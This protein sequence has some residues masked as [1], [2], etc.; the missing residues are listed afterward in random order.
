MLPLL[1]TLRCSAGRI[2]WPNPQQPLHACRPLRK[3]AGLGGGAAAHRRRHAPAALQPATRRRLPQL[4]G[5]WPW[6]RCKVVTNGW[7]P[8]LLKPRVCATT[9]R[10][11]AP[12]V[13]PAGSPHSS[14]RSASCFAHLP[15][16]QAGDS[17][18]AVSYPGCSASLSHNPILGGRLPPAAAAA[19][20]MQLGCPGR[21]YPAHPQVR[22]KSSR[23]LTFLLVHAQAGSDAYLTTRG[24]RSSCGCWQRP[25]PPPSPHQHHQALTLQRRA[26]AQPGGRPCAPARHTRRRGWLGGSHKPQEE[27]AGKPRHHWEWNG[28]G[29][30]RWW[31]SLACR[32]AGLKACVVPMCTARHSDR[33]PTLPMLCAGG[34]ARPRSWPRAGR[35]RVERDFRLG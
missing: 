27:G 14:P 33:L 25:C 19:R 4:Q 2:L 28:I 24:W 34:G 29:M 23:G 35:R 7:A 1:H 26:A 21:H 9:S 12:A 22:L 10:C 16:S 20:G 30:S 18:P 31:V 17:I 11:R 6:E 3:P 32:L 8:P 15:W 13:G 5:G